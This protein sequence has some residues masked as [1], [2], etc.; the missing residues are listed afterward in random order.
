MPTDT[1]QS[2]TRPRPETGTIGDR[3][4][5]TAP[6]GPAALLIDRGA[7]AQLLGRSIR[8]IGRDDSAGRLP[9]PVT[10]GG[11]KKWKRAEIV[12]WIDA[13]CPPRSKWEKMNK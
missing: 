4:T 11:S 8:S 12:A 13:G 1:T 9:R 5:A 2:T 10:I 6:A 7:V 3:T